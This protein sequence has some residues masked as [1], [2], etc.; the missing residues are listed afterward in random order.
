MK[1][2]VD[3]DASPVQKEVIL[4]AGKYNLSVV[5]VKSFSHFSHEKNPPYVETIYV[6]KG[7][8][9]ADFEIIKLAKQNDVVITQDYGLA[10]LC[11]GKG[12]HVVHHKGFQYTNDNIDRLLSSRHASA[13]A[14]RGG[15]RT[16]GPK[17]Y[18]EE[19]RQNFKDLLHKV[20][21]EQIM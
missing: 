8:D 10:S 17:P 16:K 7:A 13:M 15:Y 9:M 6:D 12:C 18:T 14:R 3:A 11:L 19:E 2:F 5:L 20:I 21:N 4:I 1:I